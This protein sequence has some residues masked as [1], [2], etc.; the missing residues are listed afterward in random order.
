MTRASVRQILDDAEIDVPEEL[1]MR[2]LGLSLS[3]QYWIRPDGTQLCWK[4]I[5]FFN[6]G[7]TTVS[8]L[9][10]SHS[11]IRTPAGA[12][13]DNTS[14]GNLVKRWIVRRDRRI[15]L[16]EGGSNN[17]EPFNEAVATALYRRILCD[18]DYVPYSL[19]GSAPFAVSACENFLTDEEEYVSAIYVDRIMPER[20][21]W[22][23]YQHYVRSCER[24]GV[25]GV[26]LAL[27]KA[28]VCD[29]IIAN[30]DRNYRNFGVVRNVE[31]LACKPALLLDSGSCLWL[32]TP[33]S[34]LQKGE[35][36]F[37]SKQFDPNPARQL[38]L[39][40]DMSWLEPERLGGFADEALSIL[41]SN[42]LLEERFPFI[43]RLLERRVAR[44][45]DIREWS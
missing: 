6:N 3:D 30:E 13:P 12:H 9:T 10:A 15:L 25:V 31:T 14:D 8:E 18:G 34:E 17:Q 27:W 5:N 41:A 19:E 36:S 20:D 28:I 23:R 32:N 44:I 26:E 1:A 39:V 38:L 7:F 24:I 37:R 35:F 33:L 4:D 2:N 16:K 40:E 21:D 42:R 43:R 29:D 22:S 11:P 45:L